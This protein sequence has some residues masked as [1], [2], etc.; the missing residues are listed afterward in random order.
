MLVDTMI[1]FQVITSAVPL[2]FTN[3]ISF[4]LCCFLVH[5]TDPNVFVLYSLH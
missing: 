3:M 2:C 4:L 5:S 1:S